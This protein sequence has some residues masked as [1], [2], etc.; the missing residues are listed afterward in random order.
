MQDY[1]LGNCLRGY[2]EGRFEDQSQAL[3]LL[4]RRFLMSFPSADGRHVYMCTK[5]KNAFGIMQTQVCYEGLTEPDMAAPEPQ[6]RKRCKRS[7]YMY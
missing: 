6:V 1:Y 5:A 7:P 4:S 3:R 2:F